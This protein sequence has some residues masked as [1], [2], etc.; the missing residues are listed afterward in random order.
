MKELGYVISFQS[1]FFSKF[2]QILAMVEVIPHVK[3]PAKQI[4]QLAKK[5]LTLL[6]KER[7]RN[8]DWLR[9]D[10]VIV[11]VGISEMKKLNSVYRGQNKVTDILSFDG[12]GVENLGELVICLPQLRK[13]AHEHDLTHE[14]EF[15][16]MLL[17]GILHLLG[18][19][20]EKSLPEAKLMFSIQDRLFDQHFKKA[21]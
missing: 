20:H 21:H 12:D 2:K 7:L 10:L 15:A 9:L 4:Q 11:A 1:D 3:C 17:H 5:C 6:K 14:Q 16:Y 18:Y 8:S 13:Q 19:D